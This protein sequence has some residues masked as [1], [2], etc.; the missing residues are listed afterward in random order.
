MAKK[1]KSSPVVESDPGGGARRLEGR[2]RRLV[3]PLAAHAGMPERRRDPL[4]IIADE[5]STR[6]PDLVP[7]RHGRMAV[8]PFAFYR[9]TAGVMASDLSATPTTDLTLQ[10]CGDAHIMNFGVFRDPDRRLVFDLN[11][12]DETLVGP[13]EWDVKRFATSLT[14]V[15]RNNGFKGK[16]VR[17]ITLDGVGAYRNA[18]DDAT[19]VG[20]L[21]LNYRR[22]EVEGILESLKDPAMRKAAEKVSRQAM[23]HDT[24][25]AVGKL[26]EVVDG[27]RRIVE[28]R[29]LIVRIDDEV[30]VEGPAGVAEFFDAAAQSLPLHQRYLLSRYSIVDVARKIV[31]VGSVGTRCLVVLLESDDGHPLFMQFKEAGA[32]VL[33]PYC[34][35]SPF[36]EHGERVVQGQRL[37]QTTGD[38]FLGWARRNRGDGVRDFYFRQLWD[39]KASLDPSTLRQ[40]GLSLYAALCAR[41]LGFAHARTRNVEQIA[42]YL[43]DDTTFDEAVSVFADGYA[44]IVEGDFE[45]HAAAIATGRIHAV[46][47]I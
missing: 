34:A 13:F 5:D 37:M 14:L 46:R 22:T 11:D 19:R 44:D 3:V 40:N 28:H 29:P 15:A 33:E 39:G 42:G 35:P 24:I 38:I 8:S 9:A 30:A 17:R 47:D 25:A 21:A 45:Q 41:T 31:G 18:I 4:A 10:L 6:L 1:N 7:I 27:Q 43:G 23:H 12:F 32:S 20:P 26:T 16:E 2:D 36:A